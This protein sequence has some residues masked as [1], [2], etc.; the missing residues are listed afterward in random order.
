MILLT[1]KYIKTFL[2]LLFFIIFLTITPH[3]QAVDHPSNGCTVQ[4]WNQNIGSYSGDLKSPT[5][6]VLFADLTQN[7]PATHL[8][9]NAVVVCQVTVGDKGPDILTLYSLSDNSQF[10]SN[11]QKIQDAFKP[12]KSSGEVDVDIKV[13]GAWVK[14]LLTSYNNLF[15]GASSGDIESTRIHSYGARVTYTIKVDIKNL[16]LRSDEFLRVGGAGSEIYQLGGPLISIVP[17]TQG[18]TRAFHLTLI[19][20]VKPSDMNCSSKAFDASMNR[21]FINFESISKIAIIQGKRYQEPFTMTVTKKAGHCT[22]DMTPKVIFNSA[23]LLDNQ[24]V[25]LDNGLVL[26]IKDQDG[27]NIE[28]GKPV[29]KS[30]IPGTSEAFQIQDKFSA[31]IGRSPNNDEI[32]AGDFKTTILYTMEYH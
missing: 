6:M 19:V 16:E 23:N 31:E 3:V 10:A 14:P 25:N 24:S 12:T 9:M 4:S 15:T 32:I 30:L 26:R 28:F 11:I 2:F 22:Y 8:T 29:G 5:N 20:N 13:E 27:N 1:Q 18:V 21:S 7:D 17:T